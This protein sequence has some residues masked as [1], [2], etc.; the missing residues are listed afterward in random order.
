MVFGKNR[1]FEAIICLR[2]NRE[3]WSV[4]V[5]QDMVASK[6]DNELKEYEEYDNGDK[7]GTGEDNTTIEW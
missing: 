6:F 4:S 2:E 3:W 1:L 5:V 7:E